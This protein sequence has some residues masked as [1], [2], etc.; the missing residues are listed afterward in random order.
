MSDH[1]LSL[2][3]IEEKFGPENWEHMGRNVAAAPPLS[4]ELCEKLRSLFA[5]VRTQAAERDP[6]LCARGSKPRRADSGT[7]RK[8]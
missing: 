8:G 2:A 1:E 4:P 3:E 6:R 7:E 5:V